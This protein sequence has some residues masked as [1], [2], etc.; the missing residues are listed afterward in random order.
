VIVNLPEEWDFADMMEEM[1]CPTF[2]MRAHAVYGGRKL[3]LKYEYESLKDHVLPGEA[4]AFFKEYKLFEEEA[5]YML[6]KSDA[7]GTLKDAPEKKNTNSNIGFI[8]I[9]VLLISGAIL[10]WTQRR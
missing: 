8:I 9:A 5:N 3:K 2:T 10:W 4:T 1:K 7:E 6:S